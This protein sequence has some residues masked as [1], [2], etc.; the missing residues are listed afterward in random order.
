M[1]K[2]LAFILVAA[3][4]ASCASDYDRLAD[5]KK[6]YPNCIVTPSTQLLSHQ[7]FEITVEDTITGQI[8]AISYYVGST[9]RIHQVRNIR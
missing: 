9:T 3:T 5:A 4:F 2:I 6:K 8:Y 1:K 7:G